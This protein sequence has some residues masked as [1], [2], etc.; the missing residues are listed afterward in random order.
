MCYRKFDPV[1][2]NDMQKPPPLKKKADFLSKKL[3]NDQK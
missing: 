2:V 3:R 1:L